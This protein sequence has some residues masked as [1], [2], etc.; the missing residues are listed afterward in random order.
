MPGCSTWR[1]RAPGTGLHSSVI[2][3]QGLEHGACEKQ[4][5]LHV[6]PV[7]FDVRAE[8]A[9]VR[10]EMRVWLGSSMDNM[11]VELEAAGSVLEVRVLALCAIPALRILRVVM[12]RT[13]G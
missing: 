7:S 2:G 4:A 12:R 6:P 11:A 10:D 3:I 9:A 1:T 5:L 13:L 8:A